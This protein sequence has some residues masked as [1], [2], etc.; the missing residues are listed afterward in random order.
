MSNNYKEN[1]KIVMHA[2]GGKWNVMDEYSNLN[3]AQEVL[4]SYRKVIKEKKFRL[5]KHTMEVLDV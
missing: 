1:Y 5:E 4:E 2:H 3:K